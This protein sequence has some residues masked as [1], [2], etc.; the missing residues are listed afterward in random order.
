LA[1]SAVAV[2]PFDADADG[3]KHAATRLHAERLPVRWR[4]RRWL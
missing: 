2:R 1:G 3:E 4:A